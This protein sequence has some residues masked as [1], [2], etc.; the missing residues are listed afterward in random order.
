M[1]PIP[2][3]LPQHPRDSLDVPIATSE[4]SR[5]ITHA[6]E[7]WPIGSTRAAADRW[8]D[9]GQ[10][11][12]RGLRALMSVIRQRSQLRDLWI[13]RLPQN[14]N[15]RWS[16][17]P[18]LPRSRIEGRPRSSRENVSTSFELRQKSNLPLNC[19]SS[20]NFAARKG[21]TCRKM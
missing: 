8:L 3:A 2:R 21:L 9:H 6:E 17:T 19:R 10:D 5:A 7:R 20:G 14:P 16:D 12:D 11:H 13:L 18:E 4:S 15:I 1:K